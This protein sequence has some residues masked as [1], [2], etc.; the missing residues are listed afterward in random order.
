MQSPGRA[1]ATFILQFGNKVYFLGDKNKKMEH[2][3]P[4]GR[5]LQPCSETK[6]KG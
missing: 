5:D 3:T 2:L 6:Q 1:Y 4:F